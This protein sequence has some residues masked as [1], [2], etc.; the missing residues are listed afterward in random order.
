MVGRINGDH[1]DLDA[2]AIHYLHQSHPREEVTALFLAADVMVVTPLRDGM[3]LVAKEFVVSKTDESGALVLSEFAGAAD[4]L[5]AAHLCNPTTSVASNARSSTPSRTT[6]RPSSNACTPCASTSSAMT[7]TGGPPRSSTCWRALPGQSGTAETP[8]AK[9]KIMGKITVA[10]VPSSHVYVRQ[11]RGSRVEKIRLR[12]PSTPSRAAPRLAGRCPC[13]ATPQ[14]RA[15]VRKGPCD[16][17]A[18]Q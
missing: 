14:G 2:T 1:G 5:A 12:S 8:A 11:Y 17:C 15:T 16:L 3:N 18:A 9:G 4:E 13:P 10:C 7:C 6:R